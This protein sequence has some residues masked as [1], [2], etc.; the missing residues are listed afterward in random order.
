M[1]VVRKLHLR[2]KVSAWMCS[3]GIE[4]RRN[5]LLSKLIR[6]REI[7]VNICNAAIIS[8]MF[9]A[10]A[11]VTIASISLLSDMNHACYFFVAFC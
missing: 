1:D 9:V 7:L 11:G 10:W 5:L 4:I 6:S 3:C 8:L 2:R